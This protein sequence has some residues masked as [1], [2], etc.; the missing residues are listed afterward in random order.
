MNDAPK[1]AFLPDELFFKDTN[2]VL[3]TGRL[4]DEPRIIYRYENLCWASA[5]I[6]VRGGWCQAPTGGHL[7][8][9]NLFTLFATG[10]VVAE[11]M[12]RHVYDYVEIKGELDFKGCSDPLG[13][14]WEIAVN[15]HAIRLLEP[16]V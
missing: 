9:V 12:A 16:S 14:R 3:L 4:T 2:A 10:D 13:P 5:Q 15:V 11:L 1:P 6:A 8:R 7:P